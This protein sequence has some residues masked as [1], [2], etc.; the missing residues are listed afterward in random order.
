LSKVPAVSHEGLRFDKD[1]SLYFV[2]ES[3]TGCLYKYVPK[4]TG[5]L[6]VGQSY[7]LRVTAYTGNVTLNWDANLAS[8]R[9][10]A[11]TWVP[12]TDIDGNK[13]TVA[14]PFQYNATISSGGRAAGDE[15]F[16]T[17][18][19]RPEDMTVGTDC[20]GR[21]IV[22]F[23][24]TSEHAVYA[25]TLQS[26]TTANVKIFVDRNT[27]NIATGT[28]V[29]TAFDS[30]DNLAIDYDGTIYVVE[31]QAPPVLDIWQAI[32]LDKDGVADYLAR[33]LTSGI[34][35][36]EFTGLMFHPNRLRTAIIVAQHPSSGNDAIW[37]I[38]VG[39]SPP[40]VPFT[41]PIPVPVPVAIPAPVSPPIPVPVPVAIP[42]PVSPPIPV[43]V[44][45]AI[46]APV[47]PPVPANRPTNAPF[48]ANTKAPVSKA[49][50]IKTPSA[51]PVVPP[52][53]SPTA[54]PQ[55]D[56]CGLFGLNIFCPF[57]FC[58]LFGRLLRLCD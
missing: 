44:P 40:P 24:A 51:A 52:T 30:P 3:N 46:P 16:C 45:V 7:A 17:P 11:A 43:P 21:E 1:R 6:S 29:G 13:L 27:I 31:D 10:G 5:N 56:D 4:V 20:E 2:D 58:G 53:K 47:S 41:V 19:G 18:Y 54:A 50:V 37:E 39:P 14:D 38:N 8:P 23:T 15:V 34:T 35:G 49:P 36:S 28:P 55:R 26:A 22:Y 33:W 25:V 32:D 42:A 12:I 48:K 57:T 9:V